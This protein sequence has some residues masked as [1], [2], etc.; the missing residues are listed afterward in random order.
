MADLR[1]QELGTTL[2][3]S[4]PL[5]S[6]PRLGALR[7]IS[8]VEARETSGGNAWLRGLPDDSEALRQLRAVLGCK[9][10]CSLPDG[11]LVPYE[12]TVPTSRLP[13]GEWQPLSKFLDVVLPTKRFA[14]QPPQTTAVRL[15]RSPVPRLTELLML[16]PETWAAYTRT[17]PQVRLDPLSFAASGKSVLVVGN[18]L[19]S[20]SGDH[21]T[22]D[23]GIAVP[24][25][26]AWQPSV[27]AGVLRHKLGLRADDLAIFSPEGHCSIV[28]A[29]AFVRAS[30]SAA[31]LT[32]EALRV[33]P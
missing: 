10:Y 16:S 32:A 12:G 11:Q 33:E 31:H 9:V 20:L 4:V 7:R 19:P 18:P 21:F 28:R 1:S 25:G 30:R 2:V 29:E 5:G 3:V 23:E 13:L 26:Y 15:V 22:L 8:G 17:A 27:K 14:G 24:A 6:V